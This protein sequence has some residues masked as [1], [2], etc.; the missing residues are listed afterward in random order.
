MEGNCE[1]NPENTG[2]PKGQDVTNQLT[3]DDVLKSQAPDADTPRAHRTLAAAIREDRIVIELVRRLPRLAAHIDEL[4]EHDMD[5]LAKV[6]INERISYRDVAH[7][8]RLFQEN[9]HLPR[10]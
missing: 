2:I 5:Y 10:R 6:A 1:R 4:A 8:R 7:L 3:N 9:Q